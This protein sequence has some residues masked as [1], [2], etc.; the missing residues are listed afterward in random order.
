MKRSTLD[1]FRAIAHCQDG[2]NI[3]FDQMHAARRVDDPADLAGFQSERRLLE[4]LLHVP[5]SE[6]TPF[7]EQWP[8]GQ[9]MTL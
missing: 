5:V 4:L 9:L 7:V 2:E 8:R 1:Y 3:P 6:E